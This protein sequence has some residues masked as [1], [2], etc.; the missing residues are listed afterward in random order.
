MVYTYLKIGWR[1]LWDKRIYTTINILGISI[2]AAFCFL[3]YLYVIKERSFDR[4]HRNKDNIYRLEATNIFDFGDQGG[5]HLSWMDRFLNPDDGS[6]HMLVLPYI[7]GSDI[8]NTLPDVESIVRWKDYGHAIVWFEQQSYKL[9]DGRVAYIENNFFEVFDFPLV[10]GQS[11]NVLNSPSAVVLSESTAKRIFGQ[12]NPIGKVLSFSIKGDQNFI[13]SGVVHDFPENSSINYDIM[14]PLSAKPNYAEDQ[15][16]RSLNHYNYITLLTLKPNADLAVVTQKL[17]AFTDNYFKEKVVEWQEQNPQKTKVDFQL[18]LRPFQDA[19]YNTAFPWGHFTNT[20]FLTQLIF[21]ALVLILIASTNYI[22]LTLTNTIN[23]SK[24]VGIRK[25]LGAGQKQLI[26]QFMVETGLMVTTAM[27]LGLILG[28]SAIPLFSAVTGAELTINFINSK[29][30]LFGGGL[31]YILLLGTMGLYPATIMS[32]LKPAGMLRKFSEIK[33]N[34]VLSK[35]LVIG[36]FAI[37]IVLIIATLVVTKQMRFMHEL[38]LGFTKEHVLIVENPYQWEDLERSE[39]T[40]RLYHYAEQEPSISVMSGAG[41]KFGYGFN[42]N[43][44]LI[45]EQREWIF[46]IPVDYKYFEVMGIPLMKGRYFSPQ[47]ASDSIRI[48]IPPHLVLEGSS[49]VNGAVVVNETLYKLLGEPPLDEIN[50]SLGAR[51]IGVCRDYQFFDATQ[52][53]SPAYHQIRNRHGFEFFL[54]KLNAGVNLNQT[55]ERLRS[56]WDEVTQRHPFVFTFLDEDVKRG[57]AYYIKYQQTIN[58]AAIL[59]VLISCMGLFG[60]SAIYALKKT[61][62][63]GIRKVLGASVYNVFYI[64]IK[65]IIVLTLISAALALPFTM[66]FLNKWLGN[67]HLRI[68]LHWGYFLTGSILAL[69][70]ALVTVSYHALI[71]AQSNPVNSIKSE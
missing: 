2:T 61:K 53:I 60:L 67:F 28:Y 23:R 15:V 19:H 7:L 33:L 49:S 11:S 62:E 9:D 26:A 1:N 5:Q 29:H 37:C 16:D 38:D 8:K 32:G 4:F 43:G 54:Y 59:A 45:N 52:K 65:D 3:V 31:I 47:L 44:H 13:V 51:I 56:N 71:T 58:S 21:L 64:L 48:D 20:R 10:Q 42:M 40:S 39:L 14:L 55:I 24:E 50:R 63:I 18:Y 12:Q 34:P 57:Y 68:E 25:T 46:Q 6:R 27:F 66:Y 36:Q 35:G 70:F 41:A 17:N 22:L 30:I 69:G